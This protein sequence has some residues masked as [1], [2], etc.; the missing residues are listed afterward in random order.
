MNIIG[1]LGN[2][3]F[4]NIGYLVVL[5][6]FVLRL[7]EGKD[8]IAADSMAIRSMVFQLFFFTNKL[9]YMGIVNGYNLLAII[10]RAS[11]IFSMEE[12]KMDRSI[13]SDKEQSIVRLENASYT[14]GYKLNN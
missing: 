2:S 10:E 14:Y 1:T 9:L 7:Y 13:K 12:F 3:V 8:L 6:I 11:S 5:C 4:Q